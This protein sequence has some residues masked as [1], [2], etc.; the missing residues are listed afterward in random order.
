MVGG[1]VCLMIM[2]PYVDAFGKFAACHIGLR[3]GQSV[4]FSVNS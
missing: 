2:K 4:C 1:A 3:I